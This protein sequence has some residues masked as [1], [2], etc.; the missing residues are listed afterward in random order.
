MYVC[1]KI[2]EL[3]RR[4]V[5]VPKPLDPLAEA[6]GCAYT[7]PMPLVKRYTVLNAETFA[8]AHSS[9]NSGLAYNAK[10]D[11]LAL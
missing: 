1:C 6:W 4:A 8:G 10:A 3:F 5:D 9:S 11:M 2:A 7:E